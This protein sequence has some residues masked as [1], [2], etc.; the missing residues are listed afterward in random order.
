MA[1][2]ID[3]ASLEQMIC[4]YLVKEQGYQLSTP[5]DYNRQWA[6]EPRS[7]ERFLRATQPEKVAQSQIFDNETN[8][9]KFYN[10][11]SRELSKKGVV[12]LLRNGL[13][14]LSSSFDL[15]YP[16]P[17]GLSEEAEGRYQTNIFGVTRQVQYS[18]K[19]TRNAIDLM[20]SIN[21]LPILTME[22]KN[23]LTGQ[24][25]ANAIAQYR[26]DRDPKELLLSPKRCALHLAVD[27]QT[28]AMCTELRGEAS[29]FL[30]FNKGDNGGAGNPINP[31]GLRTA[32]LWE[33]VLQKERLSDI[34]EHYAQ[35]VKTKSNGKVKESIIWPRWHQLEAVRG[36]LAATKAGKVG[37]RFLIQHSAGSGKSN[38]ITW[39]AYQLVELRREGGSLFDSIVVLTD[40]VNLDK[41]LRDNI[42][43]YDSTTDLVGWA[44][45]TGDLRRHL[46]S[47]KKITVTTVQKFG[48]LL[49]MLR[50]NL[51][52][53]RFAVIIDEAHSSQS[54]KYAAKANSALSG[55]YVD[56]LK[57]QDELNELLE[58]HIKSRKMAENANF[59]AFTATPKQKTLEVFGV[60]DGTVDEEGKPR[61]RAFHLYS[62]RQAIEEG[63]I[64]DV[65]KNYTTYQSFYQ[66]C[67]TVPDDPLFDRKEAMKQLRYFVESKPETV[68]QKAKVM[69]EHFLT[70]VAHNIG[71]EA[72]CMICTNSIE[73]AIDYYMAVT[74]LLIARGSKYRAIVAF[75][76]EHLYHEMPL[77]DAKMNGFSQ[78]KI[79]ET[80][81]SGD[82][83]FLIVA[84]MF[85]TGYDEPL[86]QAMYVDKRLSGLQA[87]Q[88]L[89]RLNRTC[90][91]KRGTFVLDFVNTADDIKNSFRPFYQ[92]TILLGESDPNRLNELLNDVEQAGLYSSEELTRLNELFWLNAPRYEIDAMLD[93]M[94][95]RFK[96]LDND[97]QVSSK[98]AMKGFV[99]TYEFLS[100]ILPSSSV[101]WEKNSTL[102]TLLIPKLPKLSTEALTEGLLQSVDLE[103]Y[104]LRK[105]Q[106]AV[107]IPLPLE[108]YELSPLPLSGGG[109]V[110][111]PEPV[112]LSEIEKLFNDLFSLEDWADTDLL[113]SG[114]EVIAEQVANYQ[115]VQNTFFNRDS[116]TA[117]Q[118]CDESTNMEIMNMMLG[119]NRFKDM[120]EKYFST[121]QVKQAV[122]ELVAARVRELLHNR[123]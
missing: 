104:Q 80:F 62:M 14:Y 64:L 91:N 72:R 109:G 28:V 68:E 103:R 123:S 82:Y 23:S 112:P 115:N 17:L 9:K 30:P 57:R 101:E 100:L 25:T 39:L 65:L 42:R 50:S 1:S 54:G 24:T 67:K 66:I 43:A 34:L 58:Q 37:Q 107:S 86:L 92:S 29:W 102:L 98:G 78:S 19:D 3:E 90:P 2:R 40:R 45:R 108:D 93:Q 13:R 15:Y 41:Q 7:L 8:R 118:V 52:D 73:R 75:S 47:G 77:T 119:D 59:Y 27:D 116:A 22:L 69:V 53:R 120:L 85:Q 38:S 88:T 70:S 46:E 110:S 44:S 10:Y 18:E 35:V 5:Q 32:Y 36:L 79:E 49:Q 117:R 111:E 56:L 114:V 48:Y 74:K 21:G 87:V 55:E 71:G 95:E 33:E 99:R 94:V 121:P 26:R 81:R 63:F 60:P 105:Q 16:L 51:S 96:L 11:L 6:L 106:E 89:S 122:N 76:G 31:G 84:D 61:F 83:R 113:R 20:V 12:A 4:D 97:M